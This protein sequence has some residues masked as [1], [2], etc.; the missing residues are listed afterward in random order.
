MNTE[1]TLFA[2]VSGMK[3]PLRW[4][5]DLLIAWLRKISFGRQH[6]I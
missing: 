6:P 5:A 4:V 3:Q 1:V 2:S